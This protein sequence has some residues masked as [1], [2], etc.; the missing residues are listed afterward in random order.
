MGS[1]ERVFQ[2]KER[3]TTVGRE[4]LGGI[5]TFMALSYIMFVQPA[6]LMKAGTPGNPFPAG[7]ILVATCM[8]SALSCL[9][10]AFLA[11][12]PIALAPA[13]GHNAFFT[14]TVCLA[15]GLSW[16][17]A[18]TAVLIGGCVFVLLSFVGFRARIME[19]IPDSLKRAIAGGIGL[20]L[21]LIGMQY[22]GLVVDAPG[23]LIKF[24]DIHNRYTLLAV[25]GLA[26]TLL[27][28][29][30]N[31]RGAVLIGIVATAVVG[32]LATAVG[33]ELLNYRGIRLPSP[34]VFFLLL[35]ALVIGVL[36]LLYGSVKLA[37]SIS[38]RRAG[39]VA[40]YG[41]A[42]AVGLAC[43]AAVV[44]A[45][46]GAQ[47]SDTFLKLDFRGLFSHHRVVTVILTFLFLDVFDCVGTLIGVGERAGLLVDGKLP[48]AQQA[49]FTD[50]AGTVVGAIMGT[51]TINSYVESAAGIQAGARTG[52][53]NV[54]TAG[55]LLLAVVLY[56]FL[57]VVASP[58]SVPSTTPGAAPAE[59]YPVIAP[60]LI[61][62][63]AMML[64]S[65]ARLN[66][67]DPTELLPA[68]L[69]LVVM[70]FTVSITE[71]I[72]LGFIAYSALKIVTGRAREAH[73][74]FHVM[75]LALLLRY[76]F[77]M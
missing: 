19:F 9:L 37:A 72:A 63:G 1:L 16:Q 8:G 54:A 74:G 42:A 14:Y 6:M 35:P 11:N 69:T 33:F 38:M 31:V 25:F 67:D 52:L 75:A 32:C 48:R 7:G 61:V 30:L 43:V 56:P 50:A 13:M 45:L 77:L 23:I 53:A 47:A 12:Y 71:G 40:F 46:P 65:L 57:S 76:I 70:P 60:A 29:A 58:I 2:L 51:S 39:D 3:Q 41:V 4:V 27:L 34:S 20:L 55:C 62:V 26:T 59:L 64:A 66:W 15:W 28:L 73:W 44:W 21:T 10:M 17:Q 22:A 36:A 24:G 18:L 49:L 68:F 5:T